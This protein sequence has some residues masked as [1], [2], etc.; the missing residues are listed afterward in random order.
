MEENNTKF[1]PYIQKVCDMEVMMTHTFKRG[2]FMAVQVEP[3]EGI[4]NTVKQVEWWV[5]HAK[6]PLPVCICWEFNAAKMIASALHVADEVADTLAKVK[7][8]CDKA[9]SKTHDVK[10]IQD[11]M[12]ELLNEG[13]S[14]EEVFK[15]MQEHEE[16]FRLPEAKVD[17]PEVKREDW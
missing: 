2:E 17:K 10:K 5:V 3:I 13:K 16:D 11:K 14:E 9:V 12:T 15:W 8:K 6:S 4:E 1:A 7:D